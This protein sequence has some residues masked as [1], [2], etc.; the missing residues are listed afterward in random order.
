YLRDNMKFRVEDYVQRGHRFAIVDEVDSIL[1]DEAR[2]PLIISGPTNQPIDLYNV[3]DAVIPVLQKDI[4]FVL[5]EKARNVTLTEDGI[6]KIEEKLH[7]DNLYD[8]ANI[9]VLHH[10]TQSL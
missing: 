2:T 5:D 8:P 6:A 7:L 10:V 1:I 3:V 4:D 9:E